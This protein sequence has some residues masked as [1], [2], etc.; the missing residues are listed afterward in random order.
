[1]CAI[2]PT[3]WAQYSMCVST[4]GN[5][6]SVQ[7]FVWNVRDCDLHSDAHTIAFVCDC[8]LHCEAHTFACTLQI[9]SV[10]LECI[11]VCPPFASVGLEC[12]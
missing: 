9:A 10:R 8:D 4:S 5:M 3:D 2:F 7:V 11:Q 6:P 1:M 12:V